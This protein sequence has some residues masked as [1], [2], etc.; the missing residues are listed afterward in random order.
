MVQ[1]AQL[2]LPNLH[3]LQAHQD[4]AVLQELLVQLVTQEQVNQVIQVELVVLL[5]LMVPQ[6]PLDLQI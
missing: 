3:N 1:Q 2:D 6:E 5:V 4:Q